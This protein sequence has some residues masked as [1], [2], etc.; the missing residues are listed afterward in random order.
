LNNRRT[1]EYHASSADGRSAQT[2]LKGK[3]LDKTLSEIKQDTNGYQFSCWYGESVDMAKEILAAKRQCNTFEIL[4]I[5]TNGQPAALVRSLG[6]HDTQNKSTLECV[7]TYL[8]K[9]GWLPAD[10]KIAK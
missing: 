9:N 2:R 8:L 6:A 1:L 3:A 5:Y 7:R 4:C 10:S